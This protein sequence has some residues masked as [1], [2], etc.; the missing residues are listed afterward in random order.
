ML[1]PGESNEI[2]TTG[3]GW[4]GQQCYRT[5]KWQKLNRNDTES[6]LYPDRE[7][8]E[9]KDST[10]STTNSALGTCIA[11]SFYYTTLLTSFGLSPCRYVTMSGVAVNLSLTSSWF[12]FNYMKSGWQAYVVNFKDEEGK[13]GNWLRICKILITRIYTMLNPTE[14]TDRR[15]RLVII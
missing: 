13:A 8:R 5:K 9:H 3:S 7:I 12:P 4:Q 6:T 2:N 11:I 14:N 15:L 10:N 1:V